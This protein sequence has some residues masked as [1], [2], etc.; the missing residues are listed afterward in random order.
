[1]S[2]AKV[3]FWGALLRNTVLKGEQEEEEVEA[4]KEVVA[5]PPP[6]PTHLCHRCASACTAR[7]V[8]IFLASWFSFCCALR[9][10]VL[11]E[12]RGRFECVDGEQSRHEPK[13]KRGKEAKVGRERNKEWNPKLITREKIQK[14]TS[15]KIVWF[16]CTKGNTIIYTTRV[17]REEREREGEMSSV[18]RFSGKK[19]EIKL[20][21]NNAPE[22]STTTLASKKARSTVKKKEEEDDDEND[23]NVVIDEDNENDREEVRRPHSYVGVF[24]PPVK[25]II[26]D[27]KEAIKVSNEKNAQAHTGLSPQEVE[28]LTKEA[29]RFFLFQ[30]E[31]SGNT[32]IPRALYTDAMAKI[33]KGKKMRNVASYILPRAQLRLMDYLGLELKEIQRVT[34]QEQQSKSKNMESTSTTSFVLRSA[35][36]IDARVKFVDKHIP[37]TKKAWRGLIATISSIIQVNGGTMEESALFRALGR[38]GIRVSYNGKGQEFK[39]WSN[40]FECEISEIIPKLVSRRVLLRD[41]ITKTSGNDYTHQY[42]LGEGA[43]EYFSQEHAGQFVKEMMRSYEEEFQGNA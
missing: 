24:D 36:P 28:H 34:S 12:R 37:E 26:K 21:T 19:R 2:Y 14:K 31:K 11:F 41:K 9:A 1:M 20:V 15:E 17:Y 32:P 29:A 4:P 7:R 38:F 5:C 35:Q 27:I 33:M 43:L 18:S 42:E 16:G 8:D 3:L 6:T 23:E 39:K 30:T 25:T 13:K 22:K 10:R 40:E